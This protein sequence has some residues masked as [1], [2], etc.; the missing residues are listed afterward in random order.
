MK[1]RNLNKTRSHGIEGTAEGEGEGEGGG[2]GGGRVQREEDKEDRARR[3]TDTHRDT[4]RKCE[5]E[6]CG[7]YEKKSHFYWHNVECGMFFFSFLSLFLSLSLS[8]SFVPNV[9]KD[10]CQFLQSFAEISEVVLLC[11]LESER[12]RERAE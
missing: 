6:V 3:A 12:R 5:A 9:T 2:G 1:T 11:E 10:T 4:E 7:L 8:L